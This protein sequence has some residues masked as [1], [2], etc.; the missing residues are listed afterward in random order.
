[1]ANSCMEMVGEPKDMVDCPTDIVG[2]P[3]VV[4]RRLYGY[5][6][7]R[8]CGQV[9]GKMEKVEGG[10]DMVVNPMEMNTAL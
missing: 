6:R 1:M 8:Y 5:G 3:K 2:G 7:Q 4:F 9:D 10:T